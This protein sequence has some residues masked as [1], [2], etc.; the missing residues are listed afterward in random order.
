MTIKRTS[1]LK[2]RHESLGSNLEEWNEM[3][4]PWTYDQDVNLEHQAIRTKACLFD[5]SGLK[6]IRVSGVDALAVC[7]D[8]CTKNLTIIYPGKS[9]YVLI[10]NENG[11][12]TDDAIMF[13]ITP[14]CWMMVH[15]GGTGMEQLQKSAENK[16][17]TIEMDDDLHNLSLQGPSAVKLLDQHTPYDLKTLKYFHHAQTTLFGYHCMLSRTGYSGERGYEIFAKAEHIVQLWDAIIEQ[18]KSEGIIPGSLTCIDMIRVEAGLFFYPYDM[19]E[20]DTPWSIG[21]GF[22][23][24][25][26]KQ[27]NYRGKAACLAAK[28]KETTTTVGVIVDGDVA[29][30]FE[31]DVIVDKNRVGHVTGACYSTVMKASICMAR[32]DMK[33]SKSGQI[34]SIQSEGGNL[35]G[36]VSTM[37]LFDPEK[38]NRSAD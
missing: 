5:L 12:I 13:H 30:E 34:I 33:Y 31:A 14:N 7:N 23:V 29:A 17:V 36:T 37:P 6:K 35:T 8:I 28:G 27:T 15:G 11:G 3:G 16:D 9:T 32:I 25:K 10:L 38:G 2:A 20:N 22:C 1:I 24:S 26:N 19:N 21:L 4:M 18:G